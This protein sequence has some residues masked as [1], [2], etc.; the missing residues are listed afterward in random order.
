MIT[1]LGLI[2]KE[3]LHRCAHLQ[4]EGRKKVAHRREP[5][6]GG[7]CARAPGRG[8]KM[9]PPRSFAA[10]RGFVNLAASPR[11][12]PWAIFFRSDELWSGAFPGSPLFCST[13]PLLHAVCTAPHKHRF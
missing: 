2:G 4:P 1:T 10:C 8:R 12:T 3:P 11:L 6:E 9:P 5:W 13:H 7:V